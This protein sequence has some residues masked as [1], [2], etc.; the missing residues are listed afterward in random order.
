MNN[1][2]DFR[3]LVTGVVVNYRTPDLLDQAVRSFHRAYPEIQLL[4]VDNGSQE[5]SLATIDTLEKEHPE[6]IRSLRF[7][8]NLYHGPAMD[9]AL[10][11][12][13]S[14]YVY[15]FDSDT[16]T[17]RS[18]FLEPMV[19]RLSARKEAYG[20]GR[21]LTVDSRGFSSENGIPILWAPYMCVD[22]EIYS[23]LPPFEHHGVPVL[24]NMEAAEKRGYRLV[25]FPVRE[26]VE[27][28]GRGTASKYGYGLGLK[29]RLHQLL[30]RLGIDRLI[31]RVGL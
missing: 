3:T 12:L 21:V 13:E 23:D 29:S 25:D 11:M 31:E 1:S 6:T 8:E 28:L 2:D 5:A 22:R 7:S 30:H 20:A 16:I 18:G 14:P 9:H 26:Y 27:H 17:R 19:E 15:L 10:Q 24:R 4:I